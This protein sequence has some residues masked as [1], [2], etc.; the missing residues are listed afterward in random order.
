MHAKT[1]WTVFLHISKGIFHLI[2]VSE[3]ERLGAPFNA[4]KTLGLKIF[5][6]KEFPNFIFFLG[7]LFVVVDS[8]IHTASAEVVMDA[9]IGEIIVVSDAFTALTVR[10][11][12][13]AFI[14]NIWHKT[15]L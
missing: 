13:H 14:R 8:L 3:S 4:L 2:P 6:E 5:P 11:V 1:Q 9:F 10:A 12:V 15:P 7:Q